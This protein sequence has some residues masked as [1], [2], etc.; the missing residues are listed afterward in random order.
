MIFNNTSKITLKQRKY[1]DKNNRKID[2][3]IEFRDRHKFHFN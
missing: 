1:I 3:T 2:V